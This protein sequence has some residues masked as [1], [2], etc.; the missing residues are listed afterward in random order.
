MTYAW[1]RRLVPLGIALTLGA[2]A[3]I[4]ALSAERPVEA[5]VGMPETYRAYWQWVS[6][7]VEEPEMALPSGLTSKRILSSPGNTRASPICACRSRRRP[8]AKR[9]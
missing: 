1:R 3:V 6:A 5:Y 2:V 4:G 7:S 8:D 9:R